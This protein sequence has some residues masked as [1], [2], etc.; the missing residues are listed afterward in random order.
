MADED[1]NKVNDKGK[2]RLHVAAEKGDKEACLGLLKDERFTAVNAVDYEKRTALHFAAYKGLSEVCLALLKDERFT[3]VNAVGDSKK[4]ALH[5][6]AY[7]GLS[8]VC[9]TLLKDERFTAVNAVDGYE[10]TA[11]HFAAS[12]GLSEVCLTL[13]KDER[14]TAVNAVDYRKKT[15][16]HSAANTGHSEVCRTLLKDE[17]FTAV[18]AVDYRKR[19]ALHVAAAHGHSEVCLTLL[20]DECVPWLPTNEDIFKGHHKAMTLLDDKMLPSERARY[21]KAQFL[22][23]LGYDYRDAMIALEKNGDDPNAA[24][25]WIM[26]GMHMGGSAVEEAMKKADYSAAADLAADLASAARDADGADALHLAAKLGMLN[27]CKALTAPGPNCLDLDRPDN[28]GHTARALAKGFTGENQKEV[29]DW[30]DSFEK[31]GE[32]AQ[33]TVAS[34]GAL[35]PLQHW[36]SADGHSRQWTTP[37]GRP[38]CGLDIHLGVDTKAAGPGEITHKLFE[39][40]SD[41]GDFSKLIAQYEALR[42]TASNGSDAITSA[43]DNIVDE[44]A[45]RF[46]ISAKFHTP[47]GPD[48]SPCVPRFEAIDFLNWRKA[49]KGLEL[50]GSALRDDFHKRA[51]EPEPDIWHC[52]VC[53]LANPAFALQCEACGTAKPGVKLAEFPFWACPACTFKNESSLGK[54]G[55]CQTAKPAAHESAKHAKAAF[56]TCPVCVLQNLRDAGICGICGTKKPAAL[57][58]DF[59]KLKADAIAANSKRSSSAK[60]AA[61]AF[62]QLRKKYGLGGDFEEGDDDDELE[63]EQENQVAAE[64][65]GASETK[66]HTESTAAPATAAQSVMGPLQKMEGLRAAAAAAAGG[67]PRSVSAA[68]VSS[69]LDEIK[70]S[71]DWHVGGGDDDNDDDD[72][73][74]N[75]LLVSVFDFGGQKVFQVIQHNYMPR[76]GV[77]T[78]VFRISHLVLGTEQERRD[79]LHYIGFW[80]HSINTHATQRAPAG[81]GGPEMPRELRCAPLVLVGTHLDKI[82]GDADGGDSKLR[83][84]NDILVKEF[85]GKGIECFQAD[86]GDIMPGREHLYNQAQDLCFFPVD[87]S[88]PR[89]PN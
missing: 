13:L 43:V 22:V 57:R 12:K 62:E 71:G 82:K 67:S 74:S 77:Y 15:A 42:Q 66:L 76:L 64:D 5:W 34:F 32:A 84:A 7:K 19:T 35:A 49:P 75:G 28:T 9:L 8:E 45:Y 21:D 86:K 68:P 3:A 81:H 4:T 83:E 6:V 48:S 44:I 29:K 59:H 38:L 55:V 47:P 10:K 54:C 14:F 36:L 56:W 25:E 31:G 61:E 41:G 30:A 51:A 17:R 52:S 2:T 60:S 26:R 50:G 11:L 70:D 73:H 79:A 69:E 87:N 63:A 33:K 37:D 40:A 88:N 39:A 1:I 27:V 89:D 72:H 46:T 23:E 53:I 16:L 24:A 78:L 20:K 58:D 85:A 80:L 18:N 65:E